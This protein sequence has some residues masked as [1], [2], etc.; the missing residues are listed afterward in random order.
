MKRNL[1]LLIILALLASWYPAAAQG[2]AFTYQGRLNESGSG[3]NGSYD[4]RFKLFVDPFGNTQAGSAV[5]TNAVPVSNGLFVVTIDFGAGVFNGSNYWLEVDVRTN[6]A[7]GYVNLN[8]LQ[9][10]T[11]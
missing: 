1:P 7:A 5:L 2:T 6:G 3:A 9:S 8:P 4:F 10:L 11:P